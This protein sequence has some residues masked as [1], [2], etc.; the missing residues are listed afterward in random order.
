MTNR[1]NAATGARFEREVASFLQ[2]QGVPVVSNYTVQIGIDKDLQKARKFDLG[3]GEPP[4][5]V[6]CKAHTWTIGANAPSAKMS[7][8]NEAMYY[9]HLAPSDYRKMLFVLQS[10]HSRTGESL[11]LYYVRS[12]S[13][14]IPRDVEI[15]E[16]DP[17]VLQGKCLHACR[18]VH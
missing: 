11:L 1:D 6:E 5:I 18:P 15:W 3:C 12:Y 17:T 8:W 16:F 13:H 2:A 9:F 4:T 7:V 10:F 14:L